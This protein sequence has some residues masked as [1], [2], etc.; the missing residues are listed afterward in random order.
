MKYLQTS[1][2]KKLKLRIIIK[3]ITAELLLIKFGQLNL[4]S[5]RRSLLI[6]HYLLLIIPTP[7]QSRNCGSDR[8]SSIKEFLFIFI[9]EGDKCAEL[10]TL[11]VAIA[12]SSIDDHLTQ[13]L[14]VRRSNNG[15]IL[16]RSKARN[17]FYYRIVFLGGTQLP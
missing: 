1:R 12:R 2:H 14:M 7:L 16:C 9:N 4:L 5:Q 8:S 17:N 11:F 6:S 13:P 3:V 15:H 10:L